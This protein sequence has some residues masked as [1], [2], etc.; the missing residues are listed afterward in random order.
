MDGEI[1]AT[2]AKIAQ[3]RDRLIGELL[4]SGLEVEELKAKG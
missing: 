2:L 3:K 1:Y 4:G